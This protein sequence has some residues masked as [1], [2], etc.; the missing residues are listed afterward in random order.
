M[1][2]NCIIEQH[3]NCILER[4]WQVADSQFP[5]M[6]YTE[7]VAAH[8]RLDFTGAGRLDGKNAGAVLCFRSGLSEGSLSTNRQSG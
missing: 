8:F 4:R 2:G 3:R 7:I 6:C 5:A 1:R